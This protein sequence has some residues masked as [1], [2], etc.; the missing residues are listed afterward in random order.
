MPRLFSV[1]SSFPCVSCFL[2]SM[3][4]RVSFR[5][6]FCFVVSGLLLCTSQFPS[7]CEGLC[8]SSLFPCVGSGLFPC[9]SRLSF[10]VSR[11]FFFPIL[12]ISILLSCVSH[13]SFL[14]CHRFCLSETR[15]LFVRD[16]PLSL[17]HISLCPRRH[18]LTHASNL[19]SWLAGR[20]SET[21]KRCCTHSP[22]PRPQ[23]PVRLLHFRV[24]VCV[25]RCNPLFRPF[26]TTRL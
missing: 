10:R 22:L 14:L 3:N 24:V 21:G 23:P 9:M 25:S 6:S 1:S 2:L 11:F 7:V 18:G 13:A 16:T 5:V 17:C 4:V 15:R 26:Q 12:C 20:S 8:V 19:P